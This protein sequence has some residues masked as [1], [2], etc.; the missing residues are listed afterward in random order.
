MRTRLRLIGLAIVMVATLTPVSSGRAAAATGRTDETARLHALFDQ[1]WE[2]VLKE[3]PTFASS[4]GD[5][6]YNRRWE[7]LSVRAV[8]RSHKAELAALKRLERIDRDALPA[9]EQLNY[10]LFQDGYRDSV[11]GYRFRD[12]LM[13]I[14]H[15]YGIQLPDGMV[16][17]IPFET[18]RDYRD[19][20]VRLRAMGRQ[21]DQTI[22]LL[23]QGLKEK[24]TLPRVVLE[25]V[26]DQIRAQLVTNPEDSAL[27]SPYREIPESIP[28]ATQKRLRAEGRAAV[29]NVVVPGYRRLLDFF[30]RRY[31]PGSRTSIAATELPDGE[32]YYAYAVRSHTTTDLTADAIHKL[33]LA[34]VT[35]IRAEMERLIKQIGFDG[36]YADFVEFLRSDDRFYYESADELLA[37]YRAIAERIEPELGRLFG[38]LPSIAMEIQPVPAAAA[39]DEDAAYYMTGTADGSR[40]GIVYVNLDELRSRPKFDMEVLMAHEGA[41]GH[42][43]QFSFALV[44]TDVPEFRR[45]NEHTAFI[46]GWALYSEG[47]GAELG[48][49]RDPYSRFGQLTAEVWRAIRLVVD[50]GIHAKGWS[51]QHAID[52]FSA[53]AARPLHDIINEVDRYIAWPGQALAYKVG[54]LRIS[55][56]R[57]RAEEHLGDRFDVKAFHDVVLGAGSV[58]LDVLEAIVDRWIGE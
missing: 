31:L 4:L 11:E 14:G 54:Q 42:H 3:N 7:D 1:E 30:E 47:L 56:L 50:T 45:H 20:A 32:A 39:P 29:K 23:K 52:Y 58:P 18:E 26:P 46:E 6:R 24:R 33:G 57:R 22:A 55:E 25:R 44:Q 28:A 10:D 40:P 48:L 51:R 12:F 37:G 2:R 43:L 21:I 19:W 53:N 35:R 8:A 36:S 38:R 49:Y 13:P 17:L 5:R 41:P 34:E 9:P 27:F 15:Q 16:S